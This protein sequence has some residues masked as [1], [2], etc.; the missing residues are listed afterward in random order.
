M[1][2]HK[3][4]PGIRARRRRGGSVAFYWIASDASKSPLVKEYPV[5]TVRLHFD[6]DEERS[7][8]CWRLTAELK[9]WLTSRG[10]G[11]QAFNGT[12]TSLIDCYQRDEDSP[13]RAVKWNTSRHYDE[14]LA[15]IAAAYGARRVDALTGKDFA[16]WYRVFKEPATPDGSERLRRAYNC[17][18][19]LRIVCNYGAAS[20]Y[21]RCA[22]VAVMLS[23]MRFSPPA[24][25]KVAM[26][27]DQA[28][29]IIQTAI[30]QG[31][32]S[33]ALA[34]ALQFELSL[35]QR[36][37]IGEWIDDET[38]RVQGIVARGMRWTGGTAWSDIGPDLVLSKTTS[39]TGTLG[40]W[41]LSRYPL[42]SCALQ[43]FEPLA[44]RVGPLIVSESTGLPYSQRNFW[45]HWRD[46]AAAA[47]V[48][49]GVWNMDSRAGG[50]TE[51]ADAGATV[52]DL[53]LHATH[54]DPKITT[55]Y[56]RSALDSTRRV[57]S[58][59]AARRAIDERSKNV[60]AERGK[61][62]EG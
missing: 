40:Q 29:A 1:P 22:E 9:E 32:P 31:R 50:I 3:D 37:V 48:P 25:R 30:A 13:Y 45:S 43:A 10:G 14:I 46:I 28:K 60:S 41:D 56:V 35:R 59:R 33:I 8:R 24:P 54:S 34:Q 61:N 12:L 16:R 53:R 20:G 15:L 44:G 39:K 7:A 23:K 27:Y 52:E 42:V 49:P 2:A 55:R 26:A 4:A 21:H 5:R 57:A 38:P 51:G 18:K 47:E 62:A 6:T 58:L 36:D 11:K 19:L 17:M